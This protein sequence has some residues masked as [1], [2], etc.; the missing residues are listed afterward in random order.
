MVCRFNLSRWK[1]SNY[2]T[3]YLNVIIQRKQ[4]TTFGTI[5]DKTKTLAFSGA[6]I[7]ALPRLCCRQARPLDGPSSER[8]QKYTLQR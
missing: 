5:A 1:L 7:A 6:H 2:N 3:I 4:I 8:A